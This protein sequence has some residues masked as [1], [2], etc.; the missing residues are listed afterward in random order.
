ME[1]KLKRKILVSL[2]T[3]LVVAALV[4]SAIGC[5]K[6]EE[7]TTTSPFSQL[8]SQ[9]T[10]LSSKVSGLET[11]VNNINIPADLENRTATVEG[12]ITSL[13]TSLGLLE[14]QINNIEPS[15][16]T[17]DDITALEENLT[18]FNNRLSATSSE[19]TTVFSDIATL[20]SDYTSLNADLLELQAQVDTLSENTNDTD[21]SN[22]IVA[23]NADISDLQSSIASINSQLSALQTSNTNLTARLVDV[24][25]SLDAI[26][27]TFITINDL[28]ISL[29]NRI[30]IVENSLADNPQV[31][32]SDY[33]L[34]GSSGYLII[35]TKSSGNFVI[36]LTLYGS[37][38]EGTPG[39]E[40]QIPTAD[41]VEIVSSNSFGSP[42]SM[43]VLNIQP[44]PTG[45]TYPNW[46]L[47]KVFKVVF[48]GVGSVNYATVATGVR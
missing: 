26:D 28:W 39:I 5:S 1:V 30:T 27:E 9:V 16:V 17:V 42:R 21:Y 4:L 19:V 34:G 2:A 36:I 46:A 3:L 47:G 8:Q 35:T 41:G 11:A 48:S 10:S 24:E 15:T 25:T 6:P 38:L 13:Q 32:I 20:E 33:S 44:T 40:Y 7:E 23:I 31:V 22:E 14:T 43:C 12:R 18:D 29:D 45:T 37:D